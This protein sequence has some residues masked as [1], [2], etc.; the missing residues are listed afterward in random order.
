[1]SED[2]EKTEEPTEHKLQEARKKGQVMKSQE[3]ISLLLLVAVAAALSSTGPPAGRLLMRYTREIYEAIPSLD[4]ASGNTAWL[5]V[6]GMIKVSAMVLLPIL[7]AAF[8]MAIIGNVAQTGFIFTAEP[9]TPKASKISPIEGFKRIFSKK[10]LLELVKQLI[11]LFI[12]GHVSY[13]TVKEAL[14]ALQNTPL[15]DISQILLFTK[16]ITF[17][18]IWGVVGAS[19]ALAAMDYIFQRKIFMK[20]M[21]MSFQE[22]KDEYKETEGDPH[23]KG[24]QRQL[25]RQASQARMMEEVPNSSAVVTN[26]VH[27]AVAIKYEQGK[28][29]AP[30]VV[31]KGERLIAMRIKAAAEANEVPVVENVPLARALFRSCKIGDKIPSDLYKAAAEILAFVYRLKYRKANLSKQRRLRRMGGGN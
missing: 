16:Q 8:V 10:S 29:D 6:L 7:A 11:K 15:W 25:Q 31:A 22:L 5:F 28:M 12:V 27:L 26:P 13:K 3:V 24:R 18:I 30:I 19:L 20:E 9:L 23:V 4:L 2:G 1:M 17:K 14:V 21:M